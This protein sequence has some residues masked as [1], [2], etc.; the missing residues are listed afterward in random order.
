MVYDMKCGVIVNLDTLEE[1]TEVRMTQTSS[2]VRSPHNHTSQKRLFPY[3]CVLLD[4][5]REIPFYNFLESSKF[6]LSAV[7]QEVC[8]Q[9]W[10]ESG[11]MKVGEFLV[12]SLEVEQ[13]PGFCI[14]SF[15]IVPEKVSNRLPVLI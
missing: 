4:P 12:D 2:L 3:Y 1:I 11:V 14:R 10:P 5:R 13:L 7:T 9:Y 8:H 6:T 15:S